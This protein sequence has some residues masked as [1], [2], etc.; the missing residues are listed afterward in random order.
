M[1]LLIKPM[2]GFFLIFRIDLSR[3]TQEL[4]S[5]RSENR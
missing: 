1:S 4:C 2:K 3:I 5:I